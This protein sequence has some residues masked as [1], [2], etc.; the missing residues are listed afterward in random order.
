MS[1]I[2]RGWLY[3]WLGKKKLGTPNYDIKQIPKR[4]ARSQFRCELRVPGIFRF[5]Y[6]F[7]LLS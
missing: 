5:L 2:I 6:S 3:G 7:F 4:G 1:D